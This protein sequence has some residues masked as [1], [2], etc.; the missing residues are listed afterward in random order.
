MSTALSNRRFR[1]GQALH[2]Q[3]GVYSKTTIFEKVKLCFPPDEVI[4]ATDMSPKA[5]FYMNGGD[6]KHNILVIGE[7]KRGMDE[8]VGE[9]Y[10]VLRQLISDGRATHQVVQSSDG[11]RQTVNLTVEGPISCWVTT[12]AG[13]IFVEHLN[14]TVQMFADESE[15]Q[16]DA[17]V[18][19]I[20]QDHLNPASTP[21]V[22][23]ILQRHRTFQKRL[24]R[25][26]VCVPYAMALADSFPVHRLEARRVI[27][28][29]LTGTCQWV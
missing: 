25:Y 19:K 13:D 26:D 15:Q 29:I 21:D 24:Q 12:T 23:E 9:Y 18:R 16:T 5:L 3:T 14:R 11:G 8:D 10:R 28:Q 6:L 20:C 27:T 1:P 22:K 17:V 2:F 4:S 7:R